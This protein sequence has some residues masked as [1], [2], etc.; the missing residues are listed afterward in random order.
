MELDTQL[1]KIVNGFRDT[2][3]GACLITRHG[4]PLLHKAFGAANR[5]FH[6][7]NTVN[8]RFDTASVTKVFTAAAVLLLIQQG[9]LR[10]SDKITELVDLSG[11]RISEDATI[12]HLLTHTS[13]I[14]DDAD[15]E[16]GED[17][18]A[19]FIEKPNY[20]IRSCRDF[21]PNFAY[22][23]PN[24]APGSD[25]RYNNCAFILLGLA[26]EA[27][28]GMDSRDFITQHIFRPCGMERTCFQAMDAVCEDTATGYFAQ[29][30]GR[31]QLVRWRKN[32]YAYPPI[33]TPDG[34]AYTT[35][36]D[37][38][39][40]LTAI[41]NA[42][43]LSPEFSSIL[44]HPHSPYTRK[45]KY[46]VHQYG[47]GFEFLKVNG[48]ILCMYKEGLNT[49][50][51]AMLSYYPQLAIGVHLLSNQDCAHLDRPMWKINANIHQL[52]FDTFTIQT[53]M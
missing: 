52:L 7:P 6:V 11:T 37:Q 38:E 53:S 1:H 31:G 12:E 13:G 27:L 17:Y 5:D 15:E 21:L 2:F 20:A 4:Q 46:G 36:G 23:A 50:V 39:R 29:C 30:D 35:V 10:F 9:K 51:A 32:I 45:H 3:S 48:H 34:G 49:G 24:F 18:A 26:I 40:F 41:R 47:Y 25:A 33:G 44:M 14:A 8:T 43:L 16:A 22:K 42:T 28:T 19:L